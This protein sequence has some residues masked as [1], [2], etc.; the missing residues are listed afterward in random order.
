MKLLSDYVCGMCGS[1]V[2]VVE[3]RHGVHLRCPNHD[4]LGYVN[5]YNLEEAIAHTSSIGTIR[6]KEVSYE[7]S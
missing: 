1:R 6:S 7:D 5:H 3:T 4:I 2:V